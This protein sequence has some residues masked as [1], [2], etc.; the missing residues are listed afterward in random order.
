METKIVVRGF[1]RGLGAMALVV[2]VTLVILTL[3]Q[4]WG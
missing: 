2:F 4:A 3:Y 1:L